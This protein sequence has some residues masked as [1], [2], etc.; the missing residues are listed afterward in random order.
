M[1]GSLIVRETES[2]GN[3]PSPITQFFVRLA[4]ILGDVLADAGCKLKVTMVPNKIV[5][6]AIKAKIFCFFIT[7]SIKVNYSIFYLLCSLIESNF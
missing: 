5:M 7:S 6:T 1:A 2:P 4:V 3:Q